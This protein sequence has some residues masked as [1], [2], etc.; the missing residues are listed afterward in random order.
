MIS[1][2]TRLSVAFL[3]LVLF[4]VPARAAP[5]AL[6]N[7][8]YVLCDDLGYGDL[9]GLNAA[10]GK[11]A[12][13]HADRFAAQ[14][15]VFTDAHSSSAVC[16]PTRYGILTGRYN[17][18]SRLQSGVLNGFS[19]PL[20]AA[21]QLTVPKLLQTA[22]YRTAGIGKWHLGMN[23][24]VTESGK[25]REFPLSGRG[26]GAGGEG[27][28][29]EKITDGPTARGFDYYFGISASLDMPPFAFIENDKFT[30]APT[31]QKKWVR[32]GIAAPGFEAVEV[33]PTLTR[34]AVNY[35]AAAAADKKRFFLY[36]SFTS[37]HTPILPS[38][39]WQG[40]SGLGKYG[41]FVMETDWALGEVLAAIKK[42]GLADDTLVVFTSDN[43]C[44]PAAD[45]Q[46]LERQGHYP[47]ADR[48]GYKA[49][50]WDGGH[51]IPFM[52]RWP[53][54][55][56]PGSRCQQL[57]C[58]ND[59][60]A[61]CAELLGTKLADNA[62]VDSVSIVPLLRGEDRALHEAVI[63]HSIDGRFAVRDRQWKLL[64]CPGSGGW[65]SPRDPAAV[66]LG[67]PPIQLYDMLADVGEEKNVQAE[68]PE[69]VARLTK[70]LETYVADGRSTPGPRQANDVKVDIWKKGPR[71]K[72]AQVGD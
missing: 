28:L 56:K 19:P 30:E 13:P 4:A 67:L 16:T 72:Q 31:V 14:G 50:A 64:L 24:P 22:G 11:I 6:P 58:L 57:I 48:R 71:K 2:Q 9:H 42:N 46:G 62:G 8:V 52:V 1:V 49:D 10:R 21:D 40:K 65:G 27:G 44:S 39:A 26:R 51:R 47:S 53:G 12:T 66:K 70:L 45:P 15:M 55:V 54:V 60:M 18:R 38:P 17:W 33:L 35:L 7:I 69:I 43:G 68:H 29:A 25:P 61:T 20:I 37:P 32:A 3:F 36:L 34:K 41:D 59:L 5:P 63:H 23:L